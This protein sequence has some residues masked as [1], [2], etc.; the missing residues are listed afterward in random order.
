MSG[1][2]TDFYGRPSIAGAQWHHGLMDAVTDKSF[3]LT[4]VFQSGAVNLGDWRLNGV[5]L[6]I[7]GGEAGSALSAQHVSGHPG[8]DAW[9]RLEVLVSRM[10][11]DVLA[12]AFPGQVSLTP[13]QTPS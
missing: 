12:A 3:L 8:V 13:T 10:L 4:A 7:N 2:L 11:G 1:R 9:Q 6:L 5:P